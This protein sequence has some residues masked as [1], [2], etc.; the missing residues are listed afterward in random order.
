MMDKKQIC[1]TI[2][3]GQKANLF[4]YWAYTSYHL[5]ILNS[6]TGHIIRVLRLAIARIQPH[7]QLEISWAEKILWRAVV[8]A[9]LQLVERSLPT[10]EIPSSNQVI[11]NFIYLQ[12][13][14]LLAVLK[15]RK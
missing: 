8:V 14:G 1:L 5:L 6:S 3:L 7:F 10:L 4:D 9:Q 15:R 13:T 2:E 11:G 12:L